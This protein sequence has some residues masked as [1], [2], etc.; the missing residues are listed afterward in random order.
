[1]AGSVRS[2]EQEPGLGTTPSPARLSHTDPTAGG[3]RPPTTEPR[4]ERDLSGRPTCSLCTDD[5]PVAWWADIA[6]PS[7]T[8]VYRPCC[9]RC[10]GVACPTER[11]VDDC[12][13]CGSP[14]GYATEPPPRKGTWVSW[15]TVCSLDCLNVAKIDREAP[16]PEPR[17]CAWCG[18]EWTPKRNSSAKTCSPRCRQAKRRAQPVQD[19]DTKDAKALLEELGL[20]PDQVLSPRYADVLAAA[21]NELWVDDDMAAFGVS[22]RTAGGPDGPPDQGEPVAG[23]E[24]GASP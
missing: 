11:P 23:P 9:A 21:L 16:S 17:R 2:W 15:V 6:T 24:G 14:T 22:E 18:R 3:R 4:R 7:G 1:M 12:A 13:V 5:M 20:D 8:R 19:Y 10:A